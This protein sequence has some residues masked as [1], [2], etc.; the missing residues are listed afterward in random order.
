MAL[1]VS[2]LFLDLLVA[3]TVHVGSSFILVLDH[4]PGQ[5]I[6]RLGH[7][8]GTAEQ[9]SL[10]IAHMGA[11]LTSVSEASGIA[12]PLCLIDSFEVG[13]I[14]HR[15]VERLAQTDRASLVY[16]ILN[17][18]RLILIGHLQWQMLLLEDFLCSEVLPITLN[19][20]MIGVDVL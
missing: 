5:T 8:V 12:A 1:F 20:F 11:H 13:L 3:E 19:Q 4:L 16:S 17:P 2:Q 6:V 7:R 18:I 9:R 15:E 10:S 14:V